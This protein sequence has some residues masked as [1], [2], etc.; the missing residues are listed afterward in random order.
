MIDLT[1]VN[2]SGLEAINMSQNEGTKHL[3]LWQGGLFPSQSK[4][5]IVKRKI[6]K[7]C[8]D[9]IS[10]IQ[11]TKQGV[12]ELNS[13]DVLKYYVKILNL[14]RFAISRKLIAKIAATWDGSDMGIK[15]FL[16]GGL[17]L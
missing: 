4:V 10:L 8:R 1:S 13:I 15:I 17:K 6:E 12:V 5:K 9:K 16:I 2:A 14:K 3:G 7:Y 11:H